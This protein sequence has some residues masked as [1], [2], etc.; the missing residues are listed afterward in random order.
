LGTIASGH[1]CSTLP[2]FVALEFHGSDVPFW[3]KLVCFRDGD[4]PVIEHGRITLTEAP[5]LG[6]ELNEDEARKYAKSGES[7]FEE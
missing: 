4:R 1:V 5:G 7:F 3:S 2:N 6:C